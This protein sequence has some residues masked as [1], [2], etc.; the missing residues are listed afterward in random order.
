MGDLAGEVAR[1]MVAVFFGAKR[2]MELG[3]V[4]LGGIPRR[5]GVIRRRNSSVRR[6]S[7]RPLARLLLATG[8]RWTLRVAA[9][10][11]STV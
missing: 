10:E 4:N 9:A 1:A 11:A 2:A 3:I 6:C 8:L 7:G 5:D